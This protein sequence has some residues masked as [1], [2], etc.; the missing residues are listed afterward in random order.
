MPR[1][2]KTH[3]PALKAKVPVEAIKEQRTVSEIAQTFS[4]HPDLVSSWK[5][6]ALELRPDIFIPQSAGPAR[7]DTD[8]EKEEL[9]RQ[10][11]HV[12]VE[13]DF[14][15]KKLACSTEEKRQRIDPF[16]SRL[17]IQQQCQLLGLSCATYD[18]VSCPES[19]EKFWLQRQID[20]LYRQI[21]HMKVEL[22]FL[23]K[24]LACSTEEKRQ[25]ID[26]FHPRLNIQQQWQLLGLSRATYDWVS[27]PESAENLWLQRQIDKLYRQIRHMKVKLDFL[28]KS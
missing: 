25:R 4:I 24:K 12:K 6:Q 18:W 9:Y 5:R 10:I 20:E 11:G 28:K 1:T 17:N 23:K 22:D 19:A 7:P 2:R 16:H 27:C 3:S 14:L 21:G 13:L 26:P 15:K 8:A